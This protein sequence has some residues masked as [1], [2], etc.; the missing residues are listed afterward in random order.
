MNWNRKYL[1]VVSTTPRLDSY[2]MKARMKRKRGKLISQLWHQGIQNVHR[3]TLRKRKRHFEKS[4]CHGFRVGW[5]N[6]KLQIRKL[7]SITFKETWLCVPCFQ[8]GRSTVRKNLTNLFWTVAAM[9]CNFPTFSLAE[10]RQKSQ[11]VSATV[12]ELSVEWGLVKKLRPL[13]IKWQITENFLN[14][15]KHQDFENA[16]TTKNASLILPFKVSNYQS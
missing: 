7:S 3:I 10:P 4:D 13:V 15:W 16:Y 6:Q 11:A 8:L 12:N 2:G 9:H 14:F 5:K 1:Q